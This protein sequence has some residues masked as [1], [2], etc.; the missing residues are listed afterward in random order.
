MRIQAA[1]RGR[2]QRQLLQQETASATSIQAAFRTRHSA[3]EGSGATSS[4][5]PQGAPVG[6]PACGAAGEEEESA[7]RPAARDESSGAAESSRACAGLAGAAG[8]DGLDATTAAGEEGEWGGS[9]AA[10][11]AAG[12]RPRRPGDAKAERAAKMAARASAKA[13]AAADGAAGSVAGDVANGV[14]AKP[15]VPPTPK[16]LSDSA[17]KR[18]ETRASRAM[19]LGGATKSTWSARGLVGAVSNRSSRRSSRHSSRAP[20]MGSAGTASACAAA[21][22][23]AVRTSPAAAASATISGAE[24]P[25]NNASLVSRPSGSILSDIQSFNAS[26]LQHVE[27]VSPQPAHLRAKPAFKPSHQDVVPAAAA[28]TA[29]NSKVS[30][31]AA[32]VAAAAVAA[33]VEALAPAA[34]TSAAATVSATRGGAKP[35]DVK[36]R[37]SG[38]ILFDIQSFNASALQHVERVSPQP[39]HLRAKPAFKPSHQ[40]VVPAA[41]W[42]AQL[43]QPSDLMGD[44]AAAAA[45]RAAAAEHGAL[46]TIAQ[47]TTIEDGRV[48]R[49]EPAPARPEASARKS[50]SVSIA[51][52]A[53]ADGAA[54]VDA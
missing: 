52:P 19:A 38:S 44:L 45:K 48:S 22:Q 41:A 11:S 53:V 40:D 43:R 27:R 13:A 15:S 23:A 29:P 12:K 42:G 16:L 20:P 32:A 54:G 51:E 50:K 28:A 49:S 1:A 37:P 14:A 34:P 17:A 24:P 5:A 6:G 46:T 31:E 36:S 33:A 39:A 35:R 18:S 2:S 26:A 4:V 30:P 8:V 47:R 3:A 10:S 7:S 25:G 9:S 21:P